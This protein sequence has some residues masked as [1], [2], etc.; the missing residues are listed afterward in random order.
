MAKEELAA[1][2]GKVDKRGRAL[3][4]VLDRR[5]VK[6]RA[7]LANRTYWAGTP[8]APRNVWGFGDP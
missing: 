3:G 2:S 1:G 6:P 7:E 5:S 4:V 8:G